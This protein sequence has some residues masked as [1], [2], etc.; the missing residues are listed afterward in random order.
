MNFISRDTDYAVRALVY[1]AKSEKKSGIITVDEIVEKEGLPER[2]LRRL[3][4][5]LVKKKLLRSYKGKEGGFSFLKSPKEIKLTDVINVFQGKVKL[6][7]CF[8]KGRVCPERKR[9]VLR[10]KLTKIGNSVNRE[11]ENITIASLS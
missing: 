3:L 2:F 4:Q 11:L 10:K 9:C 7:N 6:T 5:K 1:M 8:L